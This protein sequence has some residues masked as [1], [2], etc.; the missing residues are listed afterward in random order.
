S[1]IR[2]ATTSRRCISR[3]AGVASRSTRRTGC[4]AAERCRLCSNPQVRALDCARP[5]VPDCG[6]RQGLT[7]DR[8]TKMQARQDGPDHGKAVTMN[9]AQALE[10][11]PALISATSLD[12]YGQLVKM[13]LPRA[14][15][16]AIYDRMGL[17]V[18]L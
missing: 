17:P 14:Q 2:A 8:S 10:G 16:I 3:C 11:E 18:W 6:S 13:L 9:L 4:S 7:P 15:A 1:A 5:P 12:P